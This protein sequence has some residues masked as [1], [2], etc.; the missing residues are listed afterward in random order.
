MCIDEPYEIY[1]NYDTKKFDNLLAVLELCSL[2]KRETCKSDKE[3]EEVIKFS[4]MIIMDNYQGYK[5]ANVPG[6]EDVISLVAEL[7][8]YPISTFINNNIDIPHNL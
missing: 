4:Y 5:T 3:I 6:I 7:R 1:G 8:W 2:E